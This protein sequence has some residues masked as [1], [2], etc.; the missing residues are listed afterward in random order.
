MIHFVSLVIILL[1]GYNFLVSN[2]FLLIRPIL[3][4]SLRLSVLHLPTT[5]GAGAN[6][7]SFALSRLGF[8]NRIWAYRQNYLKYQVDHIIF[9]NTNFFLFREFF[10]LI[11]IIYIF[12]ADIFFYNYGSTLFTPPKPSEALS[13]SHKLQPFHSFFSNYLDLLQTFE[14]FLLRMLKKPYFVLYQGDDIRQGSFL[15]DKY[16][17][18]IASVAPPG[19]YNKMDDNFKKGQSLRICR[20]AKHV[21]F[22]NPDLA[23]LLPDNSSFLPY[24]HISIP[25]SPPTVCH[26]TV[27]RIAHAPTNR[28]V[29]G[30]DLI[31][32][33]LD[34]L[35]DEGFVF[36]LD[37]IENVSHG[38]ALSRLSQADLLIDQL[39]AGWYG[40]V[41]L[42]FMSYAKPVVCFIRDDDLVAIPSQMSLELPVLRIDHLNILSQLRLILSLDFHELDVV[43]LKSFEFVKR[44]HHPSS[45][46]QI[47]EPYFS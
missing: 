18:S 43:G 8:S 4:R 45:V 33:S 12:R 6:G 31:L 36:S 9:R 35:R 17:V 39:F 2:L 26:S 24:S 11:S 30:T 41:A 15:E 27:L 42:E 22:L 16:D 20:H 25:E 10:R 44:W 14:L 1:F 23:S 7:L 47:L 46:A 28:A 29:K 13:L 5:V 19:Y 37:L 32:E 40:G 21:F 34:I 38:E 3:Y